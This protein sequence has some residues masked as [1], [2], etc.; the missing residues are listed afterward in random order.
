MQSIRNPIKSQVN[1]LKAHENVLAYGVNCWNCALPKNANIHIFCNHE[2][3][4]EKEMKAFLNL[5]VYKVEIESIS[6][7]KQIDYSDFL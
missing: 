3:L 5:L 2:S 1:N 6:S 7:I 4:V